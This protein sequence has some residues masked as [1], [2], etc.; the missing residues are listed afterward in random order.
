MILDQVS[1][2]DQRLW[3]V[4]ERALLLL[5]I[6]VLGLLLGLGARPQRPDSVL[7]LLLM[8][9]VLIPVG[10]TV[11]RLPPTVRA[12]LALLPRHRPLMTVASALGAVSTALV[13]AWAL[14]NA[15]APGTLT[16]LALALVLVLVA[17]GA[18]LLGRLTRR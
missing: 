3:K 7:G 10:A 16:P 17:G 13:G 2:Y 14:Y 6:G 9:V 1:G 4:L 18:T 8:A 5:A 12:N 15:M 11:W